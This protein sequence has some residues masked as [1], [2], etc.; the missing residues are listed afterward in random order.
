MLTKGKEQPER[1]VV[2]Q[3]VDLFQLCTAMLLRMRVGRGM[4]VVGSD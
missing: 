3:G 4:V 1:V 2:N